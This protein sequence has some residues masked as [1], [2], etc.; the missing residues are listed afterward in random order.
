[1]RHGRLVTALPEGLLVLAIIF[2]A[3]CGGLVSAARCADQGETACRPRPALG[4]ATIRPV[5]V[6][7]PGDTRCSLVYRIAQAM[8]T[9]DNGS[10]S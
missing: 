1:M 7:R 9:Y 8:G 3:C 4:W 2:P 5:L 10:A 6:W